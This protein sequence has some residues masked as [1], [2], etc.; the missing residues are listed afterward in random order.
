MLLSGEV[1]ETAKKNEVQN[2]KFRVYLK[3]HAVEEELDKQ[4]LKLHNELFAGYDCTKC[5]NCCRMYRGQFENDEIER[6]AK[7]LN[8]LCDEFI[9]KFLTKDNCEMNY[10]TK[11]KPCDFL[12]DN[13]ECML[14]DCKSE[15]CKNYPYTNQPG[16]LWS[17]L[18]FID[19]VSVCPV[20]YE[21]CERLKEMYNFK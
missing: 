21:I 20:A 9:E 8:M 2:Y 17:L 6:A 3:N 7:R 19:S 15:S 1:A 18:G 5:R 10:V 14:G 16:R 13:G 12:E 11:N 4:F